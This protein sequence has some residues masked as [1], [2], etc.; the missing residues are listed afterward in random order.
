MNKRIIMINE[1]A[2]EYAQ[3]QLNDI[4]VENKGG[5]IHY[6]DLH[7][8]KFAEL[9]IQECAGLFS[10]T[11]TDEKYQRRIDKTIKKHFGVKE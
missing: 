4:A 10:L 3:A 5:V 6:S 1:Q 7:I 8:Q 9:I 11:Y 2:I